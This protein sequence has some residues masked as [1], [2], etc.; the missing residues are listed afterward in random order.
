MYTYVEEV[1]NGYAQELDQANCTVNELA[2]KLH[3]LERGTKE[4]RN[5]KH[6]LHQAQ[7]ILDKIQD[8][9]NIVENVIND[10]RGQCPE[11]FDRID[12]LEGPSGAEVDVVVTLKYNLNNNTRKGQSD[13]RYIESNGDF[14]RTSFTIY[15][16]HNVKMILNP[17]ACRN[18]NDFVATFAHECGHIFYEVFNPAEYKQWLIDNGHF[19]EVGYDGHKD[20]SPSGIEAN[21]WED[22]YREADR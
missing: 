13:I 22:K 5:T 14:G 17:K 2:E 3:G 10:Y 4:Y 6:E 12:H 16:F 20:N 19:N 18:W 1:I 15:L 11:E 21:K 7:R 9:Y 8:K